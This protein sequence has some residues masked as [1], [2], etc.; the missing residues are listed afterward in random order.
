MLAAVPELPEPP[1]LQ[2]GSCADVGAGVGRT[3]RDVLL[4][5]G[6]TRVDLVEP[7]EHL[8]AAAT[9]A[10]A[11]VADCRFLQLPAQDFQP[12]PEAYDIM[13]H[14][15]VLLYLPDPVLIEYLRRCRAALKP[16]GVLVVKENMVLDGAHEFDDEDNSVTR[17]VEQYTRLFAKA[18][19]EV[20]IEMQQR[21]WPSDLHPLMMYV[22]R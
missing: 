20:L 22:L 15:W 18:G 2:D 3:V 6:F 8:L 9:E 5:A 14:Q 17:T 16:Q 21:P 12:E 13:W 11:P 1:A 19:L 10:L 7:A 4:P